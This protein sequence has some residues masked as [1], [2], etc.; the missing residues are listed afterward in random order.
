MA[1]W[2]RVSCDSGCRTTGPKVP[3]ARELA[4]KHDQ[5]MHG[6]RKTAKTK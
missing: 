3:N 6:G 2:K 4:R 5:V 1:D